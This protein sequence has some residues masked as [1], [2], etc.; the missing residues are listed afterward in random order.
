M[1]E[2]LIRNG[3]AIFY[4]I[5]VLIIIA[6]SASVIWVPL[7]A[8]TVLILLPVVYKRYEREPFI[9][10]RHFTRGALLGFTLITMIFLIELASGF[11]RIDDLLPDVQSILIAGI[12]LQGI[13]A[14]GEELPFRGY[15]LPDLAKKYGPWKAVILSSSFFSL[16]HIP[17]IL[18]QDISSSTSIMIMLLTIM[19]AEIL[20]AVCYL[21]DGLMMS[22]GFHFTWNF[23]QY[24]VYSLREGFGGI[25]KITSDYKLVTGG[26]LGP[27]AGLLG[28]FVVVLALVIVFLWMQSVSQES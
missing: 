3:R 20:L 17:S 7:F 21:Y 16:L 18:A 23:F 28:L 5:V 22:I 27:E 9:W 4:I 15:V 12:I 14:I 26:E 13:V 1:L 24:H 6:S 19:F 8:Y 2:P 25:L 11:L 10:G